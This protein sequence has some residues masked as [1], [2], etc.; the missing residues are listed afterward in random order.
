MSCGIL[1]NC[2]THT[3]AVLR[4]AESFVCER[5]GRGIYRR[6]PDGMRL[7]TMGDFA[8]PDGS[9]RIGMAFLLAIEQA[10]TY[11]YVHRIT[12]DTDRAELQK[13]IDSELYYVKK[14]K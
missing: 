9:L 2:A 14:T 12:K 4:D 3:D 1:C 7:A 11:W 5:S 13:F 8:N 6:R 10:H